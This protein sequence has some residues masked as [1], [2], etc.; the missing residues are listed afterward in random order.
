MSLNFWEFQSRTAWIWDSVC[1]P[2]PSGWH[3]SSSLRRTATCVTS[4]LRSSSGRGF[5]PRKMVFLASLLVENTGSNFD[6][7]VRSAWS[8][9]T[10]E[11][12]VTP[13]ECQ[14]S[15]GQATL[16]NYGLSFS[17]KHLWRSTPTSGTPLTVSSTKKSVMAQLYTLWLGSFQ[18]IYKSKISR[19][20]QCLF[21]EICF[22]MTSTLGINH[23]WLATVRR[24]SGQSYRPNRLSKPRW[25]P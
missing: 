12:H 14:Y 22:Q 24:I 4:I 8:K 19:K 18:S 7:W 20:M 17:W 10:T 16:W 1:L 25:K 11:Y 13:V 23:I 6:L 5:I 2:I 9:L 3:P 15:Q 21:S